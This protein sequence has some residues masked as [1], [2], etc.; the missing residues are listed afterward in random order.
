MIDGHSLVKNTFI[1]YLKYIFKYFL[2]NIFKTFFL[3]SFVSSR[4]VGNKR[5]N[6][7]INTNIIITIKYI[8]GKYNILTNSYCIRIL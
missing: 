3:A 4:M 5:L 8:K 2:K 6:L 1:L 7:I